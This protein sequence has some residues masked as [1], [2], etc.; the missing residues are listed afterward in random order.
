M[1]QFP[2]NIQNDDRVGQKK[3]KSG[4]LVFLSPCKFFFSF[5]LGLRG[6]VWSPGTAPALPA[7][8][9]TLQTHRHAYHT[10]TGIKPP[11]IDLSITRWNALMAAHT[12]T[13]TSGLFFYYLEDT[14]KERERERDTR[15][16][17]FWRVSTVWPT[18][19]LFADLWRK[20]QFK[21]FVFKENKSWLLY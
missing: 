12:H 20:G 17:F 11:A 5:F 8:R 4:K 1:L 19:L 14:E 15:F 18:H 3:K 2:T 9:D 16:F 13:H 21:E 7:V 10:H 6:L